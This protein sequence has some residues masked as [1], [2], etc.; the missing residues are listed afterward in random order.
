VTYEIQNAV[1]VRLT[2]IKAGHLR[3]RGRPREQDESMAAQGYLPA[4]VAA[5]VV[6]RHVSRLYAAHKRGK[7][8]LSRVGSYW[9]VSG[10]DLARWA[11]RREVPSAN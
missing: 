7:L 9:Y 4:S 11:T 3:T 2:A 10:D 8:N 1:E 5:A 6:Q